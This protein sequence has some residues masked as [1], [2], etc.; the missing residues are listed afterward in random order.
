MT[1][2][3]LQIIFLLIPFCIFTSEL[4]V[5]DVTISI[6]MRDGT[7]LATDLYFPPGGNKPLP[8]LLMRSPA[9]RKNPYALLNLALLKDGYAIAIQETRNAADPNGKALP[10]F[11]DGWGEQQ[12]GYD[13]MRYLEQSPYTNGKIGTVGASAMGITQ[14]LMAPTAPPALQAQYVSFATADLYHHG[15]YEGGELCKD[16]IEQWLALYARHP[17]VYHTMISQPEYNSYWAKFNM[18]PLA[19]Q[20]KCPILH[21]GGWY[22]VFLK[23]SIDAFTHLQKDGGVGA[24]GQQKLVIGPWSHLWPFQ[25]HLGEFSYPQAALNPPIDFSP[26]KWFAKHLKGETAEFPNVLYYVMGTF[27]GSPSSG[28]VWKTANDWPIA[29][30]IKPLHLSDRL[31]FTPAENAQELSF[32]YDPGNQISTAGGRNLFLPSGPVDQR[33]I[34]NRADLLVLTSDPLE[35]DLE[36]TGEVKAILFVNTDA[37]DT[38]FSVRMTDVYPDG[39]SLLIADGITRLS[40]AKSNSNPKEITVDLASTSI[41]F[42]K[43]HKIRLIISSSNYPRFEKNFNSLKR[44]HENP[45][46]AV[47]KNTLFTGA[48][49]P[50][51]LL[52][53]IPKNN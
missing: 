3:M 2:S 49:T 5:P 30:E 42:S 18:L 9:G 8:C 45:T 43:G 36:V 35:E 47:A 19:K 51:R 41:V 39:K 28:N 15:L 13:T 24:K 6:P 25:Q 10:Y 34:E 27:D 40:Q 48:A 29:H 33:S 26:A 37:E 53:P 11:S 38:A 31:S 12:D 44:A 17:D 32:T 20:C 22:D 50:S 23:G 52:L 46:Q 1:G 14:L 4:P 21:L 7:K 16:Q